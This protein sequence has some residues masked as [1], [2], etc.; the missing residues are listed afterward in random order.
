M[1]IVMISIIVL[2]M[3]ITRGHA[4][5]KNEKIHDIQN[6]AP[7]TPFDRRTTLGLPIANG[8]IDTIQAGIIFIGCVIA[9]QKGKETHEEQAPLKEGR[10]P[11]LISSG[12]RLTFLGI[13]FLNLIR[14]MFAGVGNTLV[15]DRFS[16]QIAE[17][18]QH[19]ATLENC[20]VS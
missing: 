3:F 19:V 12:V 11:V 8:I 15:S 2:S 13:S 17:L 10:S 7:C 9:H 18:Q 14:A 5:I 1:K 16:S 6:D 4:G 20:T